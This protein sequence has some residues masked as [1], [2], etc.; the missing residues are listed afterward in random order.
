MTS[1][2]SRVFCLQGRREKGSAVFDGHWPWAPSAVVKTPPSLLVNLLHYIPLQNSAGSSGGPRWARTVAASGAFLTLKSLCGLIWWWWGTRLS[3][4]PGRQACTPLVFT[5][6]LYTV[7]PCWAKTNFSLWRLCRYRCYRC[8]KNISS[9]HTEM[10]NPREKCYW[11]L[12]M[13]TASLH[14]QSKQRDAPGQMVYFDNQ[15]HEKRGSF[16]CCSLFPGYFSVL[17]K[18]SLALLPFLYWNFFKWADARYEVFG[19]IEPSDQNWCFRF[20]FSKK[21]NVHHYSANGTWHSSYS[22]VKFN[23]INRHWRT[24]ELR[25]YFI[26]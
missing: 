1:S 11:I 6:W 4:D 19:T 26:C 24:R 21:K 15:S 12:I 7:G 3:S 22:N 10:A 14:Y 8:F 9:S 23:L 17:Q 16:F 2:C 5:V 18:R 20:C 13:H 25:T